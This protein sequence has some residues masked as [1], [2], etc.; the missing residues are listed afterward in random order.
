MQLRDH[1]AP[2]QALP[3]TDLRLRL[4]H[5]TARLIRTS[6][7]EVTNSSYSPSQ[8]LAQRE[9][10]KTSYWSLLGTLSQDNPQ[11]IRLEDFIRIVED[12]DHLF[13][14]RAPWSQS[15]LNGLQSL[16]ITASVTEIVWSWPLIR[17]IRI[18]LA[19]ISMHDRAIEPVKSWGENL[20]RG[21]L[22]SLAPPEGGEACEHIFIDF[23]RNN[24]TRSLCAWLDARDGRP[25][26]FRLAWE[27]CSEACHGWIFLQDRLACLLLMLSRT[28]QNVHPFVSELVG[29]RPAARSIA[30]QY[31]LATFELCLVDYFEHIKELCDP[32]LWSSIIQEVQSVPFDE[33]KLI[34]L[35][36]E[37][38]MFATK[39]AFLDILPELNACKYCSEVP[40]PTPESCIIP[41]SLNSPNSLNSESFLASFRWLPEDS[42]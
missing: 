7:V 6:E 16:F 42:V 21:I 12:A 8:L 33:W 9:L 40:L 37:P 1:E 19:Q 38:R 28:G 18:I 14:D 32:C 4:A 29:L 17:A 2:T 31:N 3:W 30:V 5:V 25:S 15:V 27:I 35:E 41:D 34:G 23:V 36:N 22:K 11:N 20:V 24:S 10:L 39:E 26:A 13:G